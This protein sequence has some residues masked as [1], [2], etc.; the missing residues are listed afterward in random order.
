MLAPTEA[1]KASLST[2]YEPGI[3]QTC[4][5][6]GAKYDSTSAMV[7]KSHVQYAKPCVQNATV[8]AGLR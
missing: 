8:G 4:H 7:V 1:E 5:R 3:K 2:E 6:P